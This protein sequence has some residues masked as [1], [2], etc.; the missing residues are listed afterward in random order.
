M[1]TGPNNAVLGYRWILASALVLAMLLTAHQVGAIRARYSTHLIR[2]SDGTDIALA[3]SV[4]DDWL[5]ESGT[6]F[7]Y[8]RHRPSNRLRAW[9]DAHVLRMS[10]FDRSQSGVHIQWYHRP[11]GDDLN[12]DDLSDQKYWRDMFHPTRV[13]FRRSTCSLGSVLQVDLAGLPGGAPFGTLRNVSIF[14]PSTPGSACD[15]VD[16]VCQPS[17]RFRRES[18]GALDDL[19]GHVRWVRIR[20]DEGASGLFVRQG[21]RRCVSVEHLRSG[22]RRKRQ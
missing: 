3:V 4:A 10:A 14:A 13:G 7:F 21:G 11:P 8:I 5:V 12:V 22:R 1:T 6:D 15:R 16:L 20:A 9:I 2:Q 19:I 17:D 18:F